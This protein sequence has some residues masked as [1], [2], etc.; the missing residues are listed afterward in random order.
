MGRS[1][2]LPGY[3]TLLKVA[4]SGLVSQRHQNDHNCHRL[5]KK[6]FSIHMKSKSLQREH[7][8]VLDS[9]QISQYPRI[10]KVITVT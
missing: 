3:F 7:N 9:C 10:V 2:A 1:N 8:F 4:E 5:S 6:L